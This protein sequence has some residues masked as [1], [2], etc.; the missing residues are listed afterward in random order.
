MI[1]SGRPEK[2]GNGLEH[3]SGCGGSRGVSYSQAETDV[4]THTGNR[5]FP[6]CYQGQ[7]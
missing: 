2:C 1:P 4:L 5:A 7:I 6:G 3:A